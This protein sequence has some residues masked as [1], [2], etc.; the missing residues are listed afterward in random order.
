VQANPS[1]THFRWLKNGQVISGN[2]PEITIGA[3]M[4][5]ASLACAANNGLYGD[6]ALKSEAVSIDP[7]SAARLI[8]DN[9]Q[10][11]IEEIFL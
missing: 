3:E 9:F 4:I 6:E 10:V 2:G 1:A 8:Q 7:Y 11:E 5:G